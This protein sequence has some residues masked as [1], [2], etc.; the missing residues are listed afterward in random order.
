[1]ECIILYM[2]KDLIKLFLKYVELKKKEKIY[3]RYKSF[4]DAL[5]N[6]SK[7]H[8]NLLLFFKNNLRSSYEEF[9]SNELKEGV[10][11]TSE[12]KIKELEK[13]A[14][15][16]KKKREGKKLYENIRNLLGI[17][18]REIYF[19]K[20]YFLAIK[21]KDYDLANY[22]L[23]VIEDLF[24]RDEKEAERFVESVENFIK[25]SIFK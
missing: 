5:R 10:L 1:M 24:K 6:Y 20:K 25:G 19:I 9:L 21:N 8:R 18:L 17:H 14:R 12:R 3:R 23:F 2:I 11:K 7:E 4:L 15:F 13:K 16:L 22:Y